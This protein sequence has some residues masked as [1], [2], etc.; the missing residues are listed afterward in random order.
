VLEISLICNLAVVWLRGKTKALG[1][2]K[3]VSERWSRNKPCLQD[4][5]ALLLITIKVLTL[6]V[7][8]MHLCVG[9]QQT[10]RDQSF[11]AFPK[12]HHF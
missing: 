11:C 7:W 8:H 4:T 9:F 12:M 1:N 10:F 2:G 5:F 6:E 3:S